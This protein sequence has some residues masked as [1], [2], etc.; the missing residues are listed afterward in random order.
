M[1]TRAHAHTYTGADTRAHWHTHTH[2]PVFTA[3]PGRWGGCSC[4]PAGASVS[5]SGDPAAAQSRLSERVCG[6][7]ARSQEGD[8]PC[9]GVG[10]PAPAGLRA[11]LA[12]L[13]GGG[14]EGPSARPCWAP[15]GMSRPAEVGGLGRRQSSPGAP[16]T[17]GRQGHIPGTPLPGGGQAPHQ[18]PARDQA[19]AQPA[20]FQASRGAGGKQTPLRGAPPAPGSPAGQ[21]EGWG[22]RQPRSLAGDPSTSARHWGPHAPPLPRPPPRRG[23]R[24]RLWGPPC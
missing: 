16:P 23:A 21:H 14:S 1:Q 5:L 24:H 18:P 13:S 7:A 19:T 4:P 3:G 10:R 11:A 9:P 20:A 12:A 6:R 2:A 17:P 22:W 15:A 8:R